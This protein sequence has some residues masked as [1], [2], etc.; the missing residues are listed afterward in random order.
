[1]YSYGPPHMA[2]Q[3]QDDQLEH[4]FS[5]YVRIRDVALKTCERRWTIGRSGERWSGISVLAARHDDD[6]YYYSLCVLLHQRLLMAFH[7]TP[8]DSK[9]PQISRILF[10]I[11]GRFHQCFYLNVSVRPLISNS[12]NP[13]TFKNRPNYY[14]YYYWLFFHYTLEP[15][16]YDNEGKHRSIRV[17]R[18]KVKTEFE[19]LQESLFLNHFVSSLP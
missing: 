14:H 15:S 3:K 17:P 6:D 19:S 10:R 7:W 13:F 8:S 18:S 5:S 4:T 9:S 16:I 12:S 11:S 2:E 1:M